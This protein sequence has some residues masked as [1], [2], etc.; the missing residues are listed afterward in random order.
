M[1]RII[2][3]TSYYFATKAEKVLE[4]AA[5]SSRL[6]AT[7]PA[8]DEA[9]GLCILF[10]HKD[11]EKVLDALLFGKISHSGIYEYQGPKAPVKKIK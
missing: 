11:L 6:I 8:L 3:F 9:C 10:E 2:L 1:D 7:P 4:E 5:I